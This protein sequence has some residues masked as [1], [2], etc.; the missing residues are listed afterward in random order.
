MSETQ[1]E[2]APSRRRQIEAVARD[3]STVARELAAEAERRQQLPTSS[4]R[5]CGT[6]ARADAVGAVPSTAED[7]GGRGSLTALVDRQPRT[8]ELAS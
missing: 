8:E 4:W 6:P 7:P 2:I 1:P 3:I 5:V